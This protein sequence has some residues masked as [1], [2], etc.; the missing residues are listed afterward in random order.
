MAPNA[1]PLTLAVCF[2]GQTAL[3]ALYH[4]LGRSA[5]PS[6]PASSTP[7]PA[8]VEAVAECPPAVAGYSTFDLL[9]VG[10]YCFV[11]GGAVA[12][13]CLGTWAISVGGL[14]GLAAGTGFSAAFWNLFVR[15]APVT[16]EV[17]PILEIVPYRDGGGS[18]RP[19][20]AEVEEW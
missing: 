7:A 13:G 6:S 12:L 1:G 10:L 3:V 11:I 20:A 18:R 17:E 9:R 2:G 8:L 15:Q 19:F 5:A 14:S 4:L 16:E